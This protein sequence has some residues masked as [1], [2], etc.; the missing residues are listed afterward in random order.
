MALNAVKYAVELGN[1]CKA[2]TLLNCVSQCNNNSDD[3][4]YCI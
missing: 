4:L 1:Y 3:D 2:L